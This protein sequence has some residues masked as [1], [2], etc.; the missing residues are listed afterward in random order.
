LETASRP[1]T[2]AGRFAESRRP[3]PQHQGGFSNFPARAPEASGAR[4]PAP[5]FAA[6]PPAVPA[7]LPSPTSPPTRQSV[8]P[9]STVLDYDYDSG[10][11]RFQLFK[12][13]QKA[14]LAAEKAERKKEER[15]Q[16]LVKVV[17]RKKIQG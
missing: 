9:E 5:S 3:E 2:D 1:S 17:K 6:A 8:K 7:F 10:L 13:R 15:S 14:K 4:S 11:S 16:S 12:F